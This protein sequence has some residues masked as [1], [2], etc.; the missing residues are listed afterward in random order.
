M[1]GRA[2]RLPNLAAHQLPSTYTLS[3]GREVAFAPCPAYNF[4]LLLLFPVMYDLGGFRVCTGIGIF[5]YL[6]FAPLLVALCS[7][8]HLYSPCAKFVLISFFYFFDAIYCIIEKP[9]IY[10]KVD[11][12]SC[13]P[14][15]ILL[16]RSSSGG[17]APVP[18]FM[19][20]TKDAEKVKRQ[21]LPHQQSIEIAHCRIWGT[22]GQP[23]TRNCPGSC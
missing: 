19:Q 23:V 11:L 7:D 14:P 1:P 5:L 13:Y 12:F 20:G 15:C 3:G 16:L 2:A 6:I 9:P 18:T 8:C 22:M 4:V 10:A 21:T 17:Q